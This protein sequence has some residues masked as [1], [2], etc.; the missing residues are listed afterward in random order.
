M[1]EGIPGLLGFLWLRG[2]LHLTLVYFLRI[3][4]PPPDSV[5]RDSSLPK[6]EVVKG[7][8]PIHD[9]SESFL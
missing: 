5:S 3:N 4:P 1:L 7:E 9:Q 6:Q 8:S 2:P